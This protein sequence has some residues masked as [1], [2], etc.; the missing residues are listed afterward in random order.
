MPP[1]ASP[2]MRDPAPPI[3][4]CAGSDLAKTIVE[5][6]AINPA[7]HDGA[8]MLAQRPDKLLEITG[9]SYRLYPPDVDQDLSVNR[10]SAFN[11]CLA[12][13]LVEDVIGVYLS[14]ITGS[15]LFEKGHISSLMTGLSSQATGLC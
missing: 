6:V 8:I 14:S 3:G 7:V 4:A 9:W 15:W 13:S 12:M 10:G 11:S 5:A 1:F 2:M